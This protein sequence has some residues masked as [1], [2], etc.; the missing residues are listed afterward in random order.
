[1]S[2]ISELSRKAQEDSTEYW[3]QCKEYY[4]QWKKEFPQVKAIRNMGHAQGR[5]CAY[6]AS[7]AHFNK[8]IRACAK[9]HNTLLSGDAPKEAIELIEKAIKATKAE[10]EF[11]QHKE[12]EV[13]G[14]KSANDWAK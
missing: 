5:R 1:M 14:T 8:L 10:F 2:R 6:N 4:Y 11:N 12:W 9:A 7:M 13:E 3:R